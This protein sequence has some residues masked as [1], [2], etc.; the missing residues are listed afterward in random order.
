M[1]TSQST[2]SLWSRDKV[3][4][5]FD[6]ETTGV[7]V[8]DDLP[9]SYSLV[10]YAFGQVVYEAHQIVDPGRPIPKETTAIHRIS[11]E[12]AQSFGIPLKSA[13]TQLREAL[14]NASKM[15]WIVLGMNVSFD[16]TLVDRA[17]KRHL[18]SGL[19]DLG[20]NAPTLDVL[21][22]DRHLDRYSK[23]KRRLSELAHTYDV[24]TN[25]NL[26]NS[27]VDAKVTLSV[28]LAILDR[29]PEMTTVDIRDYQDTMTKYH[30]EWLE[31]YNHW[32]QSQGQAPLPRRVW[33][34]DQPYSGLS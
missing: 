15:Q 1:S 25:D 33:P 9:V 31:S 32:R 7:N 4:L 11:D 3:I 12:I 2:S 30:D 14:I 10:Q 17:C 24:H 29:F 6:L 16:L 19:L 23:G 5:V 22:I 21:V 13:L 26:H 20:Y 18:G 8:E 34:I 28:L 27:L